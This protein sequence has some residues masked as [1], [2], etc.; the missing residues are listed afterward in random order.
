M[1]STIDKYLYG[2]VRLI[3]TNGFWYL[4]K[5]HYSGNC[6]LIA[7]L[8]QTIVENKCLKEKKPC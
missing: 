8:D 1:I 7:R 2:G 6:L 3:Y 4:I 5:A